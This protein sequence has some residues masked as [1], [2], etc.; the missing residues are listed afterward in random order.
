MTLVSWR[1]LG[2]APD[3]P[4]EERAAIGGRGGGLGEWKQCYVVIGDVGIGGPMPRPRK[5]A[6]FVCI[7]QEAQIL[8]T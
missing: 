3:I 1:E 5:A 2:P 7:S 4:L 8:V 6:T